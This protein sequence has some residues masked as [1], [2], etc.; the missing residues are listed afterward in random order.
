[1][2]F[3]SVSNLIFTIIFLL[4]AILKLLVYGWA[5]FRTGWNKFDFFV[6]VSSIMD[7]AIDA[8]IPTP[9]GG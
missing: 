5:Y 8:L 2:E 1:M 3:L 6:V 7:L 4:E 9:E